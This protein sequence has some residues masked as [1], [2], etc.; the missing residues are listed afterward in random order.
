[1]KILKHY[2]ESLNKTDL[3][4]KLSEYD[5]ITY[6]TYEDIEKGLLR[7]NK[8]PI[9]KCFLFI[10]PEEQVADFHTIGMKFPIDIYF[11]NKNK[12][13]DSNSLNN[14]AGIRSIKSKN[15][16]KYVVEIPR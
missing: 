14:K 10:L 11:Y 2:L 5:V 12:K 7:Y 15:K 4:N 6:K 9:E 13:L 1:M 3:D 16:V 8:A